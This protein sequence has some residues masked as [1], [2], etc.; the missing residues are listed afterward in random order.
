VCPWLATQSLV[1]GVTLAVY[2]A[3]VPLTFGGF[4]YLKRT[5]VTADQRLRIRGEGDSAL[6]NPNI[7]VALAADFEEELS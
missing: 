4:L 2:A 5:Q 7:Q 1:G 3:G 6:T